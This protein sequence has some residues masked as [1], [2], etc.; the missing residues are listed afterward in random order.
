MQQR[1]SVR[2]TA[3]SGGVG[4]A[5]LLR[6]LRQILPPGC[7]TAIV[8]TGDDA[9]FYG[10]HVSP[11]VDIV[12]YWMAGIADIER[13]WGIQGD[14]FVVVDQLSKLGVDTWFQLGDRDMAVGL[15]R[16]KALRAGSSLT[17]VTRDIT[18]LLNVPGTVLPMSNDPIRT[19][20][21]T[22]AGELDF[23][24]YFVREQARPEVIGVEYLGAAH[25][26]PAPGVID[27]IEDSDVVIICPSNPILSIEPILQVP[28]VRDALIGHH[29]VVAVSPIIRGAAIKGPA[30]R[31]LQMLLGDSNAAVV[32]DLYRPFCN[33]FV[34]DSSD[35][36]DTFERCASINPR[37][38]RLDTVMKSYDDAAKLAEELLGL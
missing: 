35:T 12:C 8:N 19:K 18:E 22:K 3:L 25:A 26:S 4:G 6:G 13:G 20:V 10:V 21:L 23:Q 16:T 38:H 29:H 9:E 37:T 15:Y 28:G 1:E 11:D 31:L 17:D 27:A 14:T 30:A 36:D 2:A 32:A 24:D 5:K 7:L 34:M 33:V